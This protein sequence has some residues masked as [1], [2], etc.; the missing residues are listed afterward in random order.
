MTSSADAIGSLYERHAAAYDQQRGRSLMEAC[1]LDRFLSLLPASPSVLDIGCGMGEPI[2][3][4]L[5]ARGCA[6]T[7][8]DSS[9][10]LIALCRERFPEQAWQVA[11]MRSLALGQCFDGLIAWDS[12]FHLGHEAQRRMFPIFRDHAAEGTAL[13]FT[14]GPGHGEA[15]GTFEGEPLYHA[16]LAPAEY[17]ALLHENGFIVV[18]HI[19]EDASCGGHTVWLARLR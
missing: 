11:D 16:S 2:A 10:P 8:I 13:L 18:D 19:A 4:H 15:V 3:R 12:F 5:I 9:A 14:S 1:W 17:R 6:V 7:G